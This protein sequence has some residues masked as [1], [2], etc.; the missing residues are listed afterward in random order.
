MVGS[1]EIAELEVELR[2]HMSLGLF[3]KLL[4]E[5]RRREDAYV[6][7]FSEDMKVYQRNIREVTCVFPQLSFD[8]TEFCF[9]NETEELRRFSGKKLGRQIP[10]PDYPGRERCANCCTTF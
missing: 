6:K 3:D 1:S 9:Y 4:K 2:H 10:T 8:Q 7:K 5:T